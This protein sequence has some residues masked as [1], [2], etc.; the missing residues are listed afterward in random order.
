MMTRM[1]YVLWRII[2]PQKPKNISY[3]LYVKFSMNNS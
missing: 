1:I 2:A 3:E